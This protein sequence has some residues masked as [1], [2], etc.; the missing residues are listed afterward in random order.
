MNVQFNKK[1]KAFSHFVSLFCFV[2]LL[3]E[4]G[5]LCTKEEKSHVS[6]HPG[7][8]KK[9]GSS[10]PFIKFEELNNNEEASTKNF[11]DN[12]VKPKKPLIMRSLIKSS[13]AF[14]LWTDE[15]LFDLSKGYDDIKFTVETVKKESR[16]QEIIEMSFGEFLHNYKK[17]DIYMVNEVPF[18][19]KKDVL[20]PQPY[21]FFIYLFMLL[22]Y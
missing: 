11:F 19:L 18:F 9:F 16:N 6:E 14:K 7:H 5:F 2:F 21:I 13:D 8:N 10:G 17:Q 12:Y 3:I 4:L 20:L 1:L 22:G 15:Y